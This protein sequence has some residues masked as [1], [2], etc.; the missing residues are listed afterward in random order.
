MGP[1]FSIS[2]GDGD[3]LSVGVITMGSS[4]GFVVGALV[5]NGDG[6]NVKVFNGDS[7]GLSEGL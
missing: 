4:T 5:G 1:L 3:G 2:E 6:A 7:V